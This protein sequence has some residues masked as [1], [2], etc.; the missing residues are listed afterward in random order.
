MHRTI[1][2]W[3]IIGFVFVCVLGTFLHFLF[4]LTGQTILV[5]PFS[6]V[7]E[8]IWEH[9]KLLYFPMVIFALWEYFRWG[10]LVTSFWYV[11]LL[12][13]LSGLLLVPVLYY[14]YTGIGG[15]NADWLNI[16]I[17]F[18]IAATVY[19]GET[20]LF[21]RAQHRQLPNWA[22]IGLLAIVGISFVVLTFL[23][24]HIPFFRD[25]STGSYG[26]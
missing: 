20:K 5:A 8:S 18:L 19:W 15:V 12:G 11:K 13:I 22:A 26:F 2:K 1:V 23:P 25:P 14:T 6:A 9:L 10:K 21:G 24:P 16:T 17:F 4:D 7:N 3:Q